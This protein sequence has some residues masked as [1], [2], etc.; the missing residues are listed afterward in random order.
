LRLLVVCITAWAIVLAGV[1]PAQGRA[2]A[3]PPEAEAPDQK[4]P[5]TDPFVPE[6]APVDLEQLYATGEE[7]FAAGDLEA[8]IV[9]FARGLAHIDSTAGDAEDE[10]NRRVRAYFAVS[11]A[12]AHIKAHE[13]GAEEADVVRARDLLAE[14]VERD[15]QVLAAEP[16]LEALAR[17]N[18]AW[19]NELL[20]KQEP[21]PRADEVFS[22]AEEASD[23]ESV[24]GPGRTDEPPKPERDPRRA[25][26]LG[27][28]IAG[29][30]VT[31]GSLALFIDGATLERRALAIAEDP[32]TDEQAEYIETEV[33]RL[34]R[35]RYGI[36]IP[37]L[38]V[39][40]SFLIIG[41]VL[42]RRAS[43]GPR[44]TLVPAI[45]SGQAGLVLSTRF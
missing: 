1:R 26:G 33:P 2:A 18:L 12:I 40:A 5:T 37:A 11:L 17:R 16:S 35:I 31:V 39:G 27:L 45:T 8:A 13:A 21:P 25:Q 41:G 38:A 32:P 30:A 36:A 7:R 44:T 20:Q 3:P 42:L 6:A 15:T 29:T 19:A 22:P 43:Q 10:G 9:A 28:V 4:G 24:P 34:R 14:T 23:D